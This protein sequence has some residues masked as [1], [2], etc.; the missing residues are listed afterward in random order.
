MHTPIIMERVYNASVPDTWAALTNAKKMQQWYF[1]MMPAFE[2]V[3]GFETQFN[4]NAN[5]NDYLHHW[6]VREAIP[7]KKIAYDWLYPEHGGHS[8]LT[9]ELFAE[10]GKNKG[11][12]YARRD[13]KFPAG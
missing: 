13:R 3:P 10:E 7:G 11:K 9:W 1:S 2:P 4:V 12:T 5:G 8:V 6:R